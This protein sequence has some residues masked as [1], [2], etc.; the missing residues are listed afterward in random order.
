[1]H[2]YLKSRKGEISAFS[3]CPLDLFSGE[4]GRVAHAV[5]A[6]WNDWVATQGAINNLK[7]FSWGNLLKPAEVRP[8]LR[9]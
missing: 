7:I 5:R 2:S 4:E 8:Y 3:Y 1:M 9:Y 6:L